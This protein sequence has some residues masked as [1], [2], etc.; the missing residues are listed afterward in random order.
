MRSEPGSIRAHLD[1]LPAHR[2]HSNCPSNFTRSG[3]VS[4]FPSLVVVQR[5]T[6]MKTENMET[7]AMANAS[8]EHGKDMEDKRKRGGE[9]NLPIWT[10]HTETD[11]VDT[12]A[13]LRKLILGTE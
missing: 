12:G 6:I 1:T 13:S 5:E 8:G 4:P 10:Q 2:E 11:S 9:P 7:A 3:A